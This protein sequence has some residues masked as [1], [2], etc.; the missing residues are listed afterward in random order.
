MATESSL[1]VDAIWL[2]P[3]YPSPMADF[4]YDVSDYCNVDPLFGDLPTFDRLVAGAH[5]RG[6]KVLIDW[7]PN[8]TSDQHP[9]FI[10]SRS[11]R[12][13]PKRDWYI[14][15]DPRPD[16]SRPNNWG[17]FFGG[18]AWTFDPHTGQYYLHQFVEGAARAELAQSGGPGSHARYPA[19]LA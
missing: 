17:S 11:S 3:M 14:W 5:R 12:D 16:G 4:G 13:D 1:G 10:A 8:H 2:S 15:R 19:L 18:P 9:W 6:I 7:V